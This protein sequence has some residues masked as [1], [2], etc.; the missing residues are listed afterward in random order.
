M[1]LRQKGQLIESGSCRMLSNFSNFKIKYVPLSTTN[2]MVF[3]HCPWLAS[4]LPKNKS[5][6][7]S[8]KYL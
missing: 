3:P 5:Y 8:R 2:L 6:I 1:A 7:A 4:G